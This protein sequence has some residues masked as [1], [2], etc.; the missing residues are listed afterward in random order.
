MFDIGF[1]ELLVIFILS[2]IIFGPNRLPE[3]VRYFVLSFKKL[4]SQFEEI[5]E[6]ISQSLEIEETLLDEKNKK[7]LEDLDKG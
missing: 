4:S 7:I 1:F 6:D 3:V 2:I 5:K